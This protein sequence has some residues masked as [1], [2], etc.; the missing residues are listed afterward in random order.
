MSWRCGLLVGLL[1]LVV[2]ASPT[3]LN[4]LVHAPS[5][6]HCNSTSLPVPAFDDGQVLANRSVDG[7]ITSD[8][9]DGVLIPGTT[10]TVLPPLPSEVRWSWF[11]GRWT[12]LGE[13]WGASLL[14]PPRNRR[15][16]LDIAPPSLA[17]ITLLLVGL[18]WMTW[19]YHRWS[20]SMGF[21]RMAGWCV[22]RASSM[23][24][25]GSTALGGG[26][27]SVVLGIM[28]GLF[29]SIVVGAHTAGDLHSWLPNL[30]TGWTDPP[31]PGTIHL[32]W[33][34]RDSL[35]IKT[36]VVDLSQKIGLALP[37][38]RLRK[39]PTGPIEMFTHELDPDRTFLDYNICQ[40]QTL[41]A[42]RG[43]DGCPGGQACVLCRENR[44]KKKYIAATNRTVEWS[45]IVSPP[46]CCGDICG[47]CNQKLLVA[48]DRIP[49]SVSSSIPRACGERSRKE[50][51]LC[52]SVRVN[53]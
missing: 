27:F 41:L 43:C 10:T 53:L 46:K 9:R 48:T 29:A 25:L 12:K 19:V 45:K 26:A 5:A 21:V 47:R 2:L 3:S 28:V 11:G 40:D 18:V 32:Y 24:W 34:G 31:C 7:C 36:E 16:A 14:S 6:N 49:L 17:A 39:K 42:T 37:G 22:R 1:L 20:S 15:H 30:S 38:L 33:S 51:I 13:S 23:E 52:V 4:P 44:T 50:Y 8:D 35:D